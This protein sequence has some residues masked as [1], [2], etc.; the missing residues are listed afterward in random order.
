VGAAQ[1]LDRS[2]TP[3]PLVSLPLDKDERKWVWEVHKNCDQ[4]LHQRLASFTAAQAMTLASFSVLTVARF[5]AAAGMP[6]G[7]LELLDKARVGIAF[8]G[9]FLAF[10]GWLVTYPMFKRLNYLNHSFLFRDKTYQE[11]H[12]CIKWDE[13]I[14]NSKTNQKAMFLLPFHKFFPLYKNFIPL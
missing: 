11:Y 1:M 10:V 5:N 14:W 7:R 9:L 3:D 13:D 12:D 4:L 6:E 2:E 8:F